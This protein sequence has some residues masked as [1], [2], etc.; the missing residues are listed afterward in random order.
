MST[1]RLQQ[2]NNTIIYLYQMYVIHHGENMIVLLSQPLVFGMRCMDVFVT[3][4]L[5]TYPLITSDITFLYLIL[6]GSVVFQRM[7]DAMSLL[8]S[9]L[10]STI[11]TR[12]DSCIHSEGG[13][14]ILPGIS[15]L[16]L[17]IT[18]NGDRFLSAALL[19]IS[20]DRMLIPLNLE[21]SSLYVKSSEF[22]N[23]L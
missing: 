13:T 23:K 17:M 9:S 14:D 7:G 2:H 15:S 21:Y 16:L 12:I 19:M 11:R 20:P 18:V 6:C 3:S 22:E 5:M 10:Q 4:L 1:D 8:L